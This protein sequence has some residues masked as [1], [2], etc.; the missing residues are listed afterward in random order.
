M[1]KI[2]QL[3]K[4]IG[5]TPLIE[6]KYRFQNKTRTAYFKCEWYN[7]TGS[8]K[9]RVALQII[10]DARA[11]GA[12]KEGQ[13][14]AETSSGN[15][16][17]ALCGVG[18]YLG[19]KVI[20]HMPRRMSEERKSIMKLYGGE[21]RLVENF[22]EGFEECEKLAQQGEVYLTQQFN[23]RSN[24][25]AYARCCREI[26]PKVKSISGFIAGVGTAGTLMGIGEFFKK[27]WNTPVIVVEPSA[28]SLFSKG[29]SI[30]KHKIQ[31]LSDDVIP[32]LYKPEIVDDIIGVDD[33]DAIAMAQK[34]SQKLGLAVGISGGA[35]FLG[36]VKCGKNKCL[37]V[38]PD[39]NK[40]YLSTDL[41]RLINTPLVDSIELLGYKVL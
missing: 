3:E 34:L 12:L 5:N 37:S 4:M 20:I 16:G 6:I 14:I 36:C 28:S 11:S 1:D 31:G 23:N 26:V 18:A 35:N 9:D 25:V 17:I 21:L 13:P 10:K 41:A 2:K 38:F 7:L 8:I 19:H 33:D 40:K 32:K 39:D 29:Y 30:G 27:K 22:R 15:M 24:L